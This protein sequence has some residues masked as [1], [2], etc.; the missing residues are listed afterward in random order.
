[1]AALCPRSRPIGIA[2]LARHRFVI[3]HEGFASVVRDPGRSV[4]GVL[5]DLALA[6][7]GALDRY[8]NVAQGLYAKLYLSVVGP[9][10]PRRAL[11]YVGR[12]SGPGRASAS[13]IEPILA[14]AAAFQLPQGYVAELRRH[15]PPGREPTADQRAAAPAARLP[16]R[17]PP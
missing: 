12:N 16:H 4:H 15:L 13:Y 14:A 9:S 10:G 8:E 6:D 3:M 2:Q 17:P 5:W 1:M 7:M 11:V